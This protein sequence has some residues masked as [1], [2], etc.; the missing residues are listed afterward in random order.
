VSA[1]INHGLRIELLEEHDWTVWPQF[2][3]LVQT[4]EGTWAPPPGRPRLPLTFTLLASRHVTG[5]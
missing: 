1:L 5:Q 2:V 3:W 4:A